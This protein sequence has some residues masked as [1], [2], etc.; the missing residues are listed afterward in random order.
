M[1]SFVLRQNIANFRGQL[2]RE[3]DPAKRAMLE[4]LLAEEQQRLHTADDHA[5][6]SQDARKKRVSEG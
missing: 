6:T 3:Q 1:D 2:E 5:S 4:R